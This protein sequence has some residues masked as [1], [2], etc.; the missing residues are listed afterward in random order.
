MGSPVILLDV[1]GVLNPFERPHRRYQRHRCSPN[2]MTFR[3]WLDPGHGPSLLELAESTGAELAWASYWCGTANEWIAPRIGLPELP[4]VPIPQFPGI[5]EGRTLGAWK[6]RHVA[7]WA[8]GR[9]F[10]WFEDEPDATECIAGEPDV[11]EHLL[12]E[13]DPLTGLTGEHIETAAAW[14]RALSA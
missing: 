11:A 14:L 6:A 1:D 13:I 9:P 10:V 5:E 2:G 4:F 7:A 12:V 3:L 8:E